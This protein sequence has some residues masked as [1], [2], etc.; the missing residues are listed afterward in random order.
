MLQCIK[1]SNT[2]PNRIIYFRVSA[3]E[4]AFTKPVMPSYAGAGLPNTVIQQDGNAH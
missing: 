1:R 2:L 4:K 3:G